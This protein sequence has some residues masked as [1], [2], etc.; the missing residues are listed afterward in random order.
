MKILVLNCGSSSVKFQVFSYKTESS[1]AVGLIECIG[2]ESAVLRYHPAGK[3]RMKKEVGRL[4]HDKAIN[5][6]FETI[7]NKSYGVI[8]DKKELSGIGHRVVHGGEK[9]TDSVYVNNE[10]IKEI[11][12]CIKF[13]PL[14]NPHNL[15][16]IE[17]CKELMPDVPNVA[18]FDTAFHS[19]MPVESYLYALPYEYYTKLGVRRFGFHGTSHH[20][21]SHKAAELMNKHYNQC[22]IITC[23]LGNGASMAA[24]KNGISIDTSMGFTPLEGLVMGTR[25]GDIDPAL[26]LYIMDSEK[27]TTAEMDDVLNKKSGVKGIS[28]ITNDMREIEEGYF[29]GTPH[30]KVAFEVYCHRIQ[31][32]IGAYA[33]IMGGVDAIV[34]TAGVGEKSPITRTLT[35]KGLEFMGVKLDEKLNEK[36]DILISSG[37]VNVFVIPTNEELV[38]A[39]DTKK[40][41][42]KLEKEEKMKDIRLDKGLKKVK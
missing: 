17:V 21:V 23:H 16:G 8:K 35:L 4:D 38:I 12:N 6:V 2:Q 34:F 31:K 14:H 37:K 1:L 32:Y 3:D 29:E 40:I 41:M 28:G 25:C 13:A 10:V 39:R 7:S 36:N 5:L 9:F 11:K 20:Y 24:V 18:V 33:A 15:K 30:H 22:K 26:V 42:E 19:K 27:L